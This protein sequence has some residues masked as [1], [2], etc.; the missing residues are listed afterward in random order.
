M[1]IN[2]ELKNIATVI[3]PV[4]NREKIIRKTLDSVFE[5]SYRPIE[6]VIID[7]GSSD[8]SVNICI[9]WAEH[10]EDDMFSVKIFKQENK[11][12]PSARNKGIEL[13]TGRFIQFL[14]SDDLLHPDKL[15]IQ[16]QSIL[17]GDFDISVSDFRYINSSGEIFQ[18][19][20]NSG[21]LLKK[22]ALGGSIF[23]ETPV[24]ERTLLHTVLWH[25]NLKVNQDIHF[26]LLLLFL[27]KLVVH[28]PICLCSYVHHDGKQISDCYGK[29]HPQ[30]LTRLFDLCK[31]SLSNWVIIPKKNKKY[32]P[33]AAAYLLYRFFKYHLIIRPFFFFRKIQNFKI[34]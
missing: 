4:Y 10:I 27:A 31:F 1:M 13:S 24:L 20:S 5:Q 23:I 12:A 17:N 6:L 7:D 19:V 25:K 29:V 34:V 26:N 16:I 32:I 21:N 14:D 22:M 3:V 28:V 33:L 9:N 8:E 18:E 30:Y 11:G 15:K 2:S